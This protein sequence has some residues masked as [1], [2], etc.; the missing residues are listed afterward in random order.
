EG[1]PFAQRKFL[2]NVQVLVVVG[3]LV[4]LGVFTDRVTQ[5]IRVAS[6]YKRIGA[7]GGRC[8]RRPSVEVVAIRLES[9]TADLIR[10]VMPARRT[11]RV[12]VLRD[13]H[14]QTT[15]VRH[16]EADLEPAQC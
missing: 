9:N 3:R 2:P 14:R 1:S 11:Q 8:L 5:R 6:G 10:T 7:E 16:D 12:V 13:T 15:L 4:Q